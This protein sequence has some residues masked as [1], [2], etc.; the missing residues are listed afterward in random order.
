MAE[1]LIASIEIEH[2]RGFGKK[3]VIELQPGLNAV[4][5]SNG[6]GKSSLC[7]AIEW[8]LFGKLQFAVGDEFQDEDAI[9]NRL[10]RSVARVRLTLVFGGQVVSVL[11]NR[12]AGKSSTRGASTLILE[13]DGG[14]FRGPEADS[15]LAELVGLNAPE[16]N[17]SNYLRQETIAELVLGDRD[18]RSAAIDKLLGLGQVRELLE[19]LQ[20]ATVDRSIKQLEREA[21]NLEEGVV[22]AATM[23]RIQLA[24][25]RGILG[26]DRCSSTRND[27]RG[28][29]QQA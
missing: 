17:S 24:R 22:E 27:R 29:R 20:I 26:R 3:S 11:R 8:A 18:L 7:N 28:V 4:V 16:F 12:P 15:R 6:A 2:F 13:S 10:D 19:N 1:W 9:A 14:S 21:E 25:R 5:G 23:R